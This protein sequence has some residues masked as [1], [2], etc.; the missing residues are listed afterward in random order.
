MD[1]TPMIRLDYTVDLFKGFRGVRHGLL[2]QLRQLCRI[3]AALKLPVGFWL[4][5]LL[6]LHHIHTSS[7]YLITL[8]LPLQRFYSSGTPH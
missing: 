3:I 8:S 2:P 6:L 1:F 5:S 7:L 4:R